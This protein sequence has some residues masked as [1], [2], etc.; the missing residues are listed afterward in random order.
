MTD[1]EQFDLKKA[2]F[3]AR[4]H[5][6][7]MLKFLKRDINRKLTFDIAGLPEEEMETKVAD[8]LAQLRGVEINELKV[9]RNK[10]NSKEYSFESVQKQRLW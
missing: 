8:L 1:K 3:K 10:F 2:E 7:K 9:R 4:K 6:L 5:K